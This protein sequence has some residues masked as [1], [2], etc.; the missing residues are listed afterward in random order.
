MSDTNERY[1]LQQRIA[2]LS[3]ADQLLLVESILARIR[4]KHFADQEAIQQEIAATEAW[5]IQ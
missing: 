1:E 4:D 5:Y 3:V 2:R